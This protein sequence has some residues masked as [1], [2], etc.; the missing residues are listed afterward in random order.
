[1]G[2]KMTGPSDNAFMVLQR[3]IEEAQKLNKPID[4]YVKQQIDLLKDAHDEFI[5]TAQAEGFELTNPKLGELE[6]Q[7]ISAMKQLA[8]KI[9]LP[10]KEY[11]E[12]IKAIQIRVFGKENYERFFG[13]DANS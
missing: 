6:I 10:V 7:Q 1:M 5:K 2:I 13:K 12:K 4:N 9:G 11:D 3:K 8:Q